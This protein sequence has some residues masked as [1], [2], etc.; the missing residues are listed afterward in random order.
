M[1]RDA[2]RSAPRDDGSSIEAGPHLLPSLL[3]LRTGSNDVCSSVKVHEGLKI[4]KSEQGNNQSQIRLH[5]NPTGSAAASDH[6]ETE[7]TILV[8]QFLGSFHH[9][10]KA[11]RTG[12]TRFLN[13][14]NKTTQRG[15][16]TKHTPRRST[17]CNNAAAAQTRPKR[18]PAQ[19][20]SQKK[21]KKVE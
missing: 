19:S 16:K 21:K 2:V 8:S 20:S 13:K 5:L 10:D 1:S 15:L 11:A 18:N 9:S 7:S 6:L 17:A 3:C 12:S 14:R 4:N